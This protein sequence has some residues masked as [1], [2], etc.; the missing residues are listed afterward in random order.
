[1]TPVGVEDV[2][3][4]PRLRRELLEELGITVRIGQPLPPSTHR[5]PAFTITLYPFLCT[6]E[7]GE[8][9]PHGQRGERL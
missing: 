9:T 5:Y 1:V 6:T 8:L 4:H 3:A 2:P 7:S